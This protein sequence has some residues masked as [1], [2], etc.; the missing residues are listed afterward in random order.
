MSSLDFP[1]SGEEEQ[2]EAIV[3]WFNLSKGFGFVAPADGSPDAFLHVSVLT[4]IGLAQITEGTKLSILIGQSPKGRQ[5]LDI[6][7]ILGQSEVPFSS[8]NKP[9][10]TSAREHI[11]TGPIEEMEGT[12]KWFK[13]E[14][15]FGFITPDD[16]DKDVFVH[17]SILTQLGLTTL[18]SGQR[19]KMD[20]HTSPKGREAVSI[21]LI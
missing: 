9:E 18:A 5:V 15:G 2:I 4:R 7:D 19:L 3:K 1:T 14:K 12:I 11:L 17:K 10:N 21:T 8:S 13:P 16:N 6:L 20:V